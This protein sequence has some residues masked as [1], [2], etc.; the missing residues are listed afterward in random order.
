[1]CLKGDINNDGFRG[2]RT[3]GRISSCNYALNRGCAVLCVM[4]NVRLAVSR[5]LLSTKLGWRRI[6]GLWKEAPHNTFHSSNHPESLS[7]GVFSF[8]SYIM[9]SSRSEF[10]LS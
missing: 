4:G 6:Y 3:S 9:I 2:D 10:V 1:M 5:L 7:G 8:I